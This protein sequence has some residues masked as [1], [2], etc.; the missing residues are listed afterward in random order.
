MSIDQI[1]ANFN[2]LFN[3]GGFKE[4]PGFLSWLDAIEPNEYH[5]KLE[6][7]TET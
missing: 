4:L 5:Q 3:K 1:I 7:M 2:T 6:A